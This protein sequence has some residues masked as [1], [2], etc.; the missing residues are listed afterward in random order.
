MTG[1]EEWG[2]EVWG[3]GGRRGTNNRV[4][5]SGGKVGVEWQDG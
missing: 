5:D 3:K 4:K 2:R 1:V